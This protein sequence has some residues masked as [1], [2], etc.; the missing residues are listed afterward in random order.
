METRKPMTRMKPLKP[1]RPSEVFP[2]KRRGRRRRAAP[3]LLLSALLLVLTCGGQSGAEESHRY[4]KKTGDRTVPFEWRLE[5]NGDYRLTSTAPDEKSVCAIEPDGDTRRWHLV[6]PGEELEVTAERKGATIVVRG[7]EKGRRI[8]K[9]FEIKGAPWYQAT[10]FSLRPFVRS[11]RTEIV[12]WTLL[13]DR[14]SPLK[15][16]VRK[17]GREPVSVS[18][19]RY[20]A[21]R[22]AL[23][24]TGLKGM[25][26]KGTYWFRLADGVFVKYKGPSGLPGSPTTRIVLQPEGK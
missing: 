13:P 26:W 19:R 7:T 9:T 16:R 12:F 22:M 11:D 25:F 8:E 21:Q 20:P 3:P 15:L 5:K 14:L 10:S 24:P 6:R 18:G 4:L 2:A 1:G 23:S 17:A